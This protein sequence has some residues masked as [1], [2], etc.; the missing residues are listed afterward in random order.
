MMS[1]T[2]TK[3]FEEDKKREMKRVLK[4]VSQNLS[5]PPISID[6]KILQRRLPDFEATVVRPAVELKEAMACSL[7]DQR[8]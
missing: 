1:L 6:P 5:D 7:S 8:A 3:V 2:T 4:E